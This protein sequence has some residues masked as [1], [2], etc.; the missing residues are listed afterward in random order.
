MLTQDIQAIF[1]ENNIDLYIH[2]VIRGGLGMMDCLN[3]F[4]AFCDN[5]SKDTKMIVWLNEVEGEIQ[6][7]GKTF[8]EMKV[9]QKWQDR[10]HA[11]IRIPKQENR[12][13]RDDIEKM[14]LKLQ[15]FDDA[16][17]SPQTGIVSK[18]RLQ[19]LQG[20]FDSVLTESI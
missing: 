16:I 12:L 8:E 11:I 17:N 15:T 3:T 7:D 9:Y 4:N 2:C 14:L 1:K 6:S 13:Y 19:Q 10:V 5:Y 20:Y 18:K